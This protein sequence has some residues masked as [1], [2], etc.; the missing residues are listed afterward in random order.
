LFVLS[1]PVLFGT[2]SLRWLVSD[3]GWYRSGFEKY[4]VSARTNMDPAELNR[5]A[6][7]ISRYLLLERDDVEIPVRVGNASV[8]LFNEREIRHMDD[9]RNLLHAFYSLQ[10]GAASYAIIYLVVGWFRLKGRAWAALGSKLRWGGGLTLGLFG[11]FSLLSLFSFDELFLQFHLVSFDND[12]WILDPSKDRLIM[13]FPQGFWYDSAIRLA[14]G[15]IA[16]ALVALLIGSFFRRK[17][18]AKN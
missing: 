7:E 15:T 18:S 14:L 3:V 16:Q 12:L 9:V 6:A 10:L 17:Q 11:G 5:A 8:P 13:M 1:L 4:G 2:I